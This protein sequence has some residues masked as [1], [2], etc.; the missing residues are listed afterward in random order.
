MNLTL[1]TAVA[2]A[3]VIFTIAPAVAQPAQYTAASEIDARQARQQQ[4]IERAF[5]RGDLS[6]HEMRNLRQGQR[7]IAHAE[8]QALADG[9]LNR[10][11]Y[12]HLSALLDQADE[13]IRALRRQPG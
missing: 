5:A 3:A 9:H 7:E 4:R 11:E 6:R 13:Q 10:R 2:A 8:A 1:K 12:R